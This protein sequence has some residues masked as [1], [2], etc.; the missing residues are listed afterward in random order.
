MYRNLDARIEAVVP[1]E[2]DAIRQE[3][4]ALLQ[5]YLADTAGSWE[6]QPDTTW[7]RVQPGS[8]EVALSAQEALMLLAQST[9]TG[10]SS[11]PT[12]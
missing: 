8:G 2:D 4:I 11:A 5:L 6:L 1:V 9:A 3:L 7:R 10:G 12:G